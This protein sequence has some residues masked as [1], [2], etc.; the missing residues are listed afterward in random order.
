MHQMFISLSEYTWS[1]L[2][3]F[4]SFH[5]CI[6]GITTHGVCV[7]NSKVPGREGTGSKVL[8]I[9]QG[10]AIPRGADV[11]TFHFLSYGRAI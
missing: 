1:F 5:A 2:F 6:V 3:S 7:C 9:P 11:S 10:A 4:P 8:G